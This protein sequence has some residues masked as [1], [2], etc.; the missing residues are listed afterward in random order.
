MK[1]NVPTTM[2]PP[3]PQKL[4][5]DLNKSMNDLQVQVDKINKA[6][7]KALRNIFKEEIKETFLIKI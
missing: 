5:E 3:N 6:N 2:F 7:M 1:N 4:L